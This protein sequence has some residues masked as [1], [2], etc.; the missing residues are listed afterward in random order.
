MTDENT[1]SGEERSQIREGAGG[2]PPADTGTRP[3]FR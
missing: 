3:E 2:S 1:I